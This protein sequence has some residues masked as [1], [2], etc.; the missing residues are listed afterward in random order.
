[1]MRW[2]VLVIV[3]TAIGVGLIT[4]GVKVWRAMAPDPV[5]STSS[6]AEASIP[7]AEDLQGLFQ[8]A[9]A[10]FWAVRDIALGTPHAL[11]TLQPSFLW[12][13]EDSWNRTDS[14]RWWASDGQGGTHW[15]SEAEVLAMAGVDAEAMLKVRTFLR[16][17]DLRFVSRAHDEEEDG[18][19]I[20]FHPRWPE[21]LRSLERT[22][23]WHE[24]PEPFLQ[25]ASY[26]YGPGKV[27]PQNTSE[28]S[29]GERG[30]FLRTI[31]RPGYPDRN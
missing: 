17:N 12:W 13:G 2:F 15:K 11:L 3:G 23:V 19:T 30:W 14:G 28:A 5:P 29:L 22:I 25:R 8:T 21:G 9:E 31:A 24:R 20:T 16:A 6:V 27:F 26:V 1:M 18:P 4:L 7:T 10:D